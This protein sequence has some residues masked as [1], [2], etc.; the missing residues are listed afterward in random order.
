[1][2]AGFG[3]GG[4]DLAARGRPW[5]ALGRR[6]R[7][8]GLLALGALLVLFAIPSPLQRAL[9]RISFDTF[10][11]LSP[12]VRV[13]ESVVIVAIDEPSLARYGQWPWPRT[14]LAQLVATI[15]AGDPAAIGID[16]VMPEP[17]RLSPDR[18]PT[19]LAGMDDELAA[20]LRALENHDTALARSLL[21]RPVVLGA[22]GVESD[23]LLDGA[24]LRR[25]PVL[26]R[27]PDPTHAIRRFGG[28]L[29][30]IDEIAGAAAGHGLLNADPDGGVV[31]RL[32]LVAA[33][34]SALVPGLAIE[35]LRV[36]SGAPA[37]TVRAGAR[38]VESVQ[39]G[40][41]VVPT[42]PDGSV[43]L[44]FGPHDPGRFVSAEAVL[45]G[46]VDPAWFNHKLVLIGVTAIGLSDYRATPI[47][48]R[49]AGVEIHAQLLEGILDRALPRRPWWAPWAEG[50]ALALAGFALVL[51]VPILPVHL[52]VLLALALAAAV[53][54]LGFL[55]FQQGLLLDVTPALGLGVIYTAMLGTTLKESRGQRRAL[56]RQLDQE[57][58]ATARVAGELEAARR[59]QMG[60]L[61]DPATAFPGERRFH[62]CA[63][64]E[65]AQEVGGDFYD[66]FLLDA[67]HLLFAIGDVSGKGLPGSLFMA[68]SKSLYK[69]AALRGRGEVARI[70]REANDEISRDNR[71]SVFVT[72]FAGV[73]DLETGDLQYCNAGHDSPYLLRASGGGT[74]A[75]LSQGAGPPLCVVDKFAY[76]PSA[77]RLGSGDVLCLVTDGVIEAMNASGEL[78]GR[79]RLE[80]QLTGLAPGA[81]PAEVVAA[82]QRDVARFSAGT[83]AADDMALLALRW[84]GVEKRPWPPPVSGR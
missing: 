47:A 69:S 28:V 33:V 8:L 21:D 54:G 31:R 57:R 73:L 30:T 43:W 9:G 61:P 71:E 12:R 13:S 26:V 44:H 59:I 53:V 32:P 67:H 16:I 72:V 15:A 27:G 55:A 34:G 24:P 41:L 35:M 20:R 42:R 3:G 18:L 62:L 22:A 11:T 5:T 66:F 79:A 76:E 65:P 82:V 29:G 45:E 60:I 50:L 25:P 58:E 10:Q 14:R 68:L 39:L 74:P 75:R 49:M 84:I 63:L 4:R 37:L 48:E 70:M 83:A 7:P 77:V 17:D 40:D 80:A 64:L 1:M 81:P 46:H 56:R 52:S 51:A 38:G 2:P 6:G 23:R 36:A 78:Y 19:L